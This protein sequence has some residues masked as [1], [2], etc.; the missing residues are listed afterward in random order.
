MGWHRPLGAG[1]ALALIYLDLD[2]LKAINDGR[3]HAAGDA[4]LKAITATLLYLRRCG[5]LYADRTPPPKCAH[6]DADLCAHK[7]DRR[8]S[9]THDLRA[10][11]G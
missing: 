2:D 10:A 7:W 1:R 6:A 11:G 4:V 9:A 8:T 5:V 3:G